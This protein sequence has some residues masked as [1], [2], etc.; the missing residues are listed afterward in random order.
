MTALT[1]GVTTTVAVIVL[2]LWARHRRRASEHNR[3]PDA[4]LDHLDRFRRGE[5]TCEPWQGQA[6]HHLM[7]DARTVRT[8]R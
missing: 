1:V 4:W 5:L 3:M 2:L 7:S 6:L 8:V